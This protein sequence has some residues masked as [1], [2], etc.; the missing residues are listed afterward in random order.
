[1]YGILTASILVIGA[2]FLG[3]TVAIVANKAWREGRDRWRRGR[4]RLLEPAILS[5]AHGDE[6]SV[7]PALR[8][9]LRRRDRSVVGEILLDH[10]QRVRGVEKRRL[11]T[12]FDDLGYVDRYLDRLRRPRWWV[13]ADAADKLGIAGAAR[14]TERLVTALEDESPEVRIRAAK[15]L[16]EVGGT[17]AVAPLVRALGEPNRWSTIRI[18]DILAT[19]RGGV[20]AQLV[21]EFDRMSLHARLAAVDI[22]GRLRS[23]EAVDWL[24]G[25]LLDADRDVRARACHALG[26]IGDP[27]SGG[28]LVNAL[29]DPEWPVRAMAA[30]ALGRIRH[31]AAI[32]ALGAA[33]RDREWWVRANAAEALRQMGP[34]GIEA[35]DR[36]LDDRDV[37]A[38]HQAVLMLEQSGEL[39]RQV[40]RLGRPDG[41]EREAA[42][43]LVRRFVRAGQVGRLRELEETHADPRVREALAGLLGIPRPAEGRP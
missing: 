8:G 1:M 37:Y 19:M 7:L 36:M 28:P 30:K 3:L 2:V 12:A 13:R 14:A 21:A 38:R 32:P 10:A 4:R 18:A 16:G 31:V 42:E 40:E 6:P 39:D 22:L 26:A 17:A 34:R 23:L 27:E 11:G 25:R 41:P 33:L 35:L 15:A 24:R 9:R 43:S 20:G 5:Y 29:S